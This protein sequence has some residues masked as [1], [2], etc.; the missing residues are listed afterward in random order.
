MQLELD[1]DAPDGGVIGEGTFGRVLRMKG[2]LVVK[3]IK[4]GEGSADEL[5][6]AEDLLEAELAFGAQLRGSRHF[7]PILGRARLSQQ[8]WGMLMP[9]AA[10]KDLHSAIQ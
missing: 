8:E 6:Q 9:L 7:T 10:P 3:T 2:G 5:R 4:H 1:T